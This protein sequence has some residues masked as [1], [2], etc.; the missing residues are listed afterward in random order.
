MLTR[1]LVFHVASGQS[2]FTGAACLIVAVGLSALARRPYLRIL[3]NTL[4]FYGVTLIFLS[5]TPL[6]PWFEILLVLASLSWVA[7]EAFRGRLPARVVLG[8]RVAVA[9]LWAGAMLVE[10]PYHLAP[11]VPQLGRPI[12]GI[13]GDSVTA[14]TN[15]SK[16]KTWPGVFA[17]RHDVVVHDHSLA[18]ANVASALRQAN[19][20]S[21]DELLVLLEIGGNDIL[22]ETTPAKFEAGLATLLSAVRRPGRVLVMLELPLPPTYNAY[23]RIQRRLA[24]QYNA[25][26]VPKRVLLGVLQQQGMTVDS[27]HLS[28]A[29]HQ[30]MANAIW[31]VLQG[32][33]DEKPRRSR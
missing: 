18:G 21:S 20:V 6:P 1:W 33:Y 11:T 25:L 22:G 30:N 28:Q 29:G 14:G 19:S 7:G 3:R 13:I 17:N 24:R 23:G 5:A 2:F 27:I 10:G 12:L 32:A 4:V 16:V 31:A 26:L 15:Q 8:L 9:I